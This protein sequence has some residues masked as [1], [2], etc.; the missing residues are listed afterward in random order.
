MSPRAGGAGGERHLQS[1]AQAGGG[2][3]PA[4][5][6]QSQERYL[7]ERAPGAGGWGRPLP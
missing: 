3:G 1:G 4:D 6:D 2:G 5:S 7:E